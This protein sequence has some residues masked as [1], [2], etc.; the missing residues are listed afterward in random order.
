[1]KEFK[2]YYLSPIGPLEVS[3]TS[4]GIVSVTFVKTRLPNDR[5]LPECV[6]EGIRQ[7]EEYFKG[8]RKNFSLKLLLQGTP[9][10]KL[11]WQRLKKIPYGKLASYG[12]VARA[13]GKPNAY[14]AVGN[15]NNKNPIAIIIPCHRVIGSDGTLVGYGGG[16]WRKEWLLDH[17]NPSL[18]S[19][20]TKFIL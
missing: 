4:E 18:T 10:Q 14:R 13:I 11:V 12:E 1:M 16:L 3:G 2:A 7:L 8:A 17:E 9:F 15:A 5:N 6:K 20:G 19:M